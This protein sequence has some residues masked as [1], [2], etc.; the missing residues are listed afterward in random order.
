MKL[1]IAS[2]IIVS[3]II[4]TTITFQKA[5]GT[6]GVDNGKIV[7]NTP[8]G[9]VVIGEKSSED[10]QRKELLIYKTNKEGSVIWSKSYGGS[11]TY[12]VNDAYIDNQQHI[13]LSSERYL[14]NRESLI[15]M[16][17][18]ETGNLITSVPYDEGGNEV[19]PWAIAPSGNGTNIIV[20]FTKTAD[21]V[22]G[23]FYNTSM[24]TK[25]LYILKIDEN[26]NK[27][28]SKKLNEQTI[29]A[30]NA[31][32]IVKTND[33]NFL[34]IGSMITE[35]HLFNIII[36]IDHNGTILWHKKHEN[37]QLTFRY[38]EDIGN[39][40]YLITGT[41]NTQSSKSDIVAIKINEEG[42]MLWS[43][44]YGAIDKEVPKGVASINDKLYLAGTSKSL[45]SKAEQIIILEIN[46]AN[47]N[48]N[49]V[50]KYGNGVL[51][52]PSKIINDNQSL[53]F[54]GFALQTANGAETILMKI[55]NLNKTQNEVNLS[56]TNENINFINATVPFTNIN[57][58][59][60]SGS[61]NINQTVITN[62]NLN[63]IDI[64]L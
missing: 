34:I 1:I 20:G 7:L 49:W 64:N 5:I 52:E 19:E 12:V 60:Y 63:S 48:L 62:L 56:T 40:N 38:I 16:E 33:N 15:Y 51:N 22:P 42:N 32:D 37:Q 54:S 10:H 43:K 58:N 3:S 4:S 35:T 25:H 36:K 45:N 53:V 44:S 8:D 39:N 61:Y 31:Y 2:L 28:W 6:G 24:E 55:D 21:F 26:G 23:A 13:H 11:E 9:Y 14:S 41:K 17:L 27:I 18:D 30:S 29:L 46:K 50:N 59:A 47:G 57:E